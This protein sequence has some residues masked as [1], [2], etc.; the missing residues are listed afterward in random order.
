MKMA[1]ALSLLAILVLMSASVMAESTGRKVVDPESNPYAKLV[2]E[3][4]QVGNTKFVGNA[5]IVGSKGCH[6]V[7]NYHVAFGKHKDPKTGEIEIVENADIGHIVN[8]AFDLDGKTGIFRRMMKAKVI[9]FGNYEA[10]TTQGLVGDLAI[11]QLESCM[12]TEYGGPKLDRPEAGKFTPKGNLMT[13]STSRNEKGLNE[14]LVEDGCKAEARTPAAGIMISNCDVRAGMSGSMI[15][16]HA[17]DGPLRLVGMSTEGKN[18]NDGSRISI[19][20]YSRALTKL[21]DSAIGG[22]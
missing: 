6:I 16:E 17:Q 10:D 22:R 15:L 7:T 5:F 18:L 4:T 21:I 3:V 14:I 13:V 12:G 11:L 1:K 9:D 20:I 19:A 2:G 8:F